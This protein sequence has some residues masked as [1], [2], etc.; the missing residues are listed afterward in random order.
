MKM[1]N[2]IKHKEIMNRTKYRGLFHTTV[3]IHPHIKDTVDFNE[4]KEL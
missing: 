2:Q 3:G 4:K 1:E